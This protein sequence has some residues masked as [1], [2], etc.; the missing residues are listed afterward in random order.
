[1]TAAQV[2]VTNGGKTGG[3][4]SLRHPAG[5]G[6]EV[7]LPAPYWNHLPRGGAPGR[8][9]ARRGGRTTPESG[10]KV[11]VEQLERALTPRTKVLLFVSPSNPTG[12]VYN[13]D[14]MR[15]WALGRTSAGCGW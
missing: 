1:V 14:E 11:T 12:A 8:R 9:G 5:P 6:D 13:E 2:L 15:A 4:G 10:Y 7:L 3:R